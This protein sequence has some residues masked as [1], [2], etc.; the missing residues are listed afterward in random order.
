MT[1]LSAER[2]ERRMMTNLEE[3]V[4]DG[5]AAELGAYLAQ[6]S[7]LPG[8]MANLKLAAQVQDLFL[9]AAGQVEYQRLFH[10]ACVL[11]KH[12]H[13]YVRMVAARTF[14]ALGKDDFGPCLHHL[15]ELS[16]DESWRVR[17]GAAEGIGQLL[18]F[19]FALVYPELR[20]WAALKRVNLQRAAAVGL[21]SMMTYDEDLMKA[22]TA[23]ILDLL[24]LLL[25]TE[26]EY[27]SKNVS[28]AL[29]ICGW[30]NPDVV[31]PRMAGW[32]DEK[33]FYSSP[34]ALRILA[35]SLDTRFG[36]LNAEEASAL[37]KKISTRSSALSDARKVKK[38]SAL[39]EKVATR[40]T[41]QKRRR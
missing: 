31:L 4:Q 32:L 2:N 14:G 15:K 36:K 26:E 12:E 23:K 20:S 35:N 3:L 38:L 39:A 28:F 6:H 34:A 22:K 9:A 21:V 13:E 33:K 25:D 17:E 1:G 30:K 7:N 8:K 41:T 5:N 19:H 18:C 11:E 24:E 16:D 37:L 27:V 40:I 10:S 29:N